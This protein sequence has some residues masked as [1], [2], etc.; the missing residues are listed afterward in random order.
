M[1]LFPFSEP[2]VEYQPCVI[3]MEEFPPEQLRQHNACDCVMCAPCLERT[4][5]HHQSDFDFEDPSPGFHPLKYCLVNMTS[6]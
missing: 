3:C 4:V 5:E 6:F 2:V 1:V